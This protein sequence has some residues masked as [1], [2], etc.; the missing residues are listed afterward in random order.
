MSDST[1]GLRTRARR[2]LPRLVFDFIE[3]SAES[4]VTLKRNLDELARIALTPNCFTAVEQ[5]DLSAPVL[6]RLRW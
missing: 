2:R 6:G 4:E 3:G 1:G 5:R